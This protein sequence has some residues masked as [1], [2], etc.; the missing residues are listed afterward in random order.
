M[1]KGV[2]Y[3]DTYLIITLLMRVRSVIRINYVDYNVL[4][5]YSDHLPENIFPF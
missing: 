5:N 2:T 3:L 1:P 4:Q